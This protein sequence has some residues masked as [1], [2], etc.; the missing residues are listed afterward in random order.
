ML[1]QV[2]ITARPAVMAT[3]VPPPSPAARCPMV[4]MAAVHTLMPS[5]AWTVFTAVPTASSV[6]LLPEAAW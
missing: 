5:A 2:K 3:P 4:T 6:S 1:K